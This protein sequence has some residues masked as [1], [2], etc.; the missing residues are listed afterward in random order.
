MRTRDFE[1]TVQGRL[2]SHL[3]VQLYQ[4]R[5]AAIAELVANAWDACAK[6]CLI[7]VPETPEEYAKDCAT[8]I[9]DDDGLGMKEEEVESKYLKLSRNRR[10]EDSG[11]VRRS[12]GKTTITRSVLGRKGI[13]KLAGFGIAR[14]VRVQTWTSAVRTATE[15]TMDSQELEIPDG[16]SGKVTIPGKTGLRIP[17]LGF[18]SGTRVILENLFAATALDPELLR[19]SLGRRFSR[20]ILG[21]MTVTVNGVPISEP[22]EWTNLSLREPAEDFQT[23]K[24]DDGNEIRY[25]LGFS[26]KPI[27]PLDAAGV[28]ILVRGKVAQATPFWFLA[29]TGTKQ[30][31]FRYLTGVVEADYLDAGVNEDPDQA[32]VISTDRQKIRWDH[33]RARSLLEWGNQTVRTLVSR[34]EGPSGESITNLLDTDPRL[35]ERVGNLE[36]NERAKVQRMAKIVAAAETPDA[37]AAELLD[38]LVRAFEFRQFYDVISQIEGRADDPDQFVHLIDNL[39]NW[40]VLESRALLEIVSGRLRIV[41]KFERML[42]E[43]APER[44]AKVGAEN[45]HDLLASHPWILNPDFVVLA[46]E[47]TIRKTLLK[48][49][50]ISTS[51]KRR[52]D[53]LALSRDRER[54]VVIEIKAPSHPVTLDE[55]QRLVTY[56][57]TYRNASYSN[58]A[59]VLIANAFA[60]NQATVK[61]FRNQFQMTSWKKIFHA[62]RQY[63]EHYRGIL[64]LDPDSATFQSRKRE[65]GQLRRTLERGAA[66]GSDQPSRG[67]GEQDS[68]IPVVRGIAR[69]SSGRQNK[70][71]TKRPA[72]TLKKPISNEEATKG[73]YPDG[74]RRA[75]AKRRKPAKKRRPDK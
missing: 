37:R 51:D 48:S 14:V 26:E 1:M 40:Q 28:V 17:D 66:R 31:S 11:A 50:G 56:L 45:L 30:F 20:K 53:F 74:D 57:D 19:I 13:G 2:L 34:W 18:A 68:E 55:M 42:V 22:P 43:K 58:V 24:L 75:A 27:R 62:A 65:I 21:E 8:V 12:F 25:W 4:T 7:T 72:A 61:S 36:P 23:V 60:P 47:R 63:L 49:E 73:T 35:A 41:D 69:P 5:P 3:G 6:T 29:E 46:E 33:Q 59:G 10:L 64:E 39:R 54:L 67:L 38:T 44:A 32:D 16:A 9:V 70:V 15:F 71:A 52:I